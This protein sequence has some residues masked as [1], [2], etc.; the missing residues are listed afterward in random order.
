MAKGPA[1]LDPYGA[2][3]TEVSFAKMTEC[4]ILLFWVINAAHER[5]LL[6]LRRN[7]SV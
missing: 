6:R 4:G 3:F 5:F 2:A 1:V 7:C